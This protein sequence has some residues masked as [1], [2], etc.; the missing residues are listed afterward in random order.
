MP[1]SIAYKPKKKISGISPTTAFLATAA[2]AWA[3]LQRIEA[4]DEIVTTIYDSK[5]AQFLDRYQLQALA[6]DEAKSSD[7]LP[8]P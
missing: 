7:E 1:Y 2:A 6:R 5:G 8:L 4:S 3:F